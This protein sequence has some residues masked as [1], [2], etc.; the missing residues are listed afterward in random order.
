MAKLY[1]D[2]GY[3]K[4]AAEIYRHLLHQ[5]PEREDI[6][7]ALDAVERQIMAQPSPTRKDVELMLREWADLLKKKKQKNNP[8]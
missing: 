7:Q 1:A 4:K 6:R 8:A 5:H 2:Q 3:L